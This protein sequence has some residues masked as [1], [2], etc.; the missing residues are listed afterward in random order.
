[1][2]AWIEI[3]TARQLPAIRCDGRYRN[4]CERPASSADAV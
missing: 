3:G 2:L 1:M 4:R